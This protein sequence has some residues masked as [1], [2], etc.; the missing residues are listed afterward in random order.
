MT[1]GATR[2]TTLIVAIFLGAVASAHSQGFRA[3]HRDAYGERFQA[4]RDAESAPRRHPRASPH[5]ALARLKYWN[6]I[7]LDCNALDHTPVAFQENRLFGEQLGPTRTSRALAIIHV[8]IFDAINAITGEFQTYSG[9]GA[10]PRDAS[11]N[12]AIAQAA[13]D[14]LVALFPS[15]RPALDQLLVDDLKQLPK[16]RS[17]LDGIDVGRRAAAAILALRANDGSEQPEARLAIEFFSSNEPGKW[18]QDPVSQIPIA[19]GVRWGSVRPF[20]IESAQRFRAPP[21]PHLTSAEYAAAFNEVVRFGG[22][23]VV[24]P[25]ERTTEQTLLALYWAYDGTAQLGTPPRLYNQIAVQIATERH[26]HVAELARLLVLINV[27]M[28]DAAIAAWESKYYYQFWR[29]ITAIRE[30][31]AG[32]GPTGLGDGNSA[33]VGNPTFTPLGAPAT[34][35]I[36]PNFTPP[37]PAYVSGHA[38]F[39]GALFQ[40]LRRFFGTDGVTFTFVSDELNGIMR[41]NTGNIRPLRPRSF[42]SLSEAEEENAQS[43]MYLGIHYQFDKTAG[44]AQGRQIADDVF[45]RAFR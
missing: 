41:D 27:A 3:G 5:N 42:Q 15:Q 1:I 38:A 37:F 18:R 35:F 9:V 10:G 32:T 14:T 11:I 20:V 16:G 26:F 12:A 19:L 21:P 13:H 8:A 7:A 17:Q 40:I 22:D 24:T 45:D 34:N 36:G 25:T 44:V 2:F 31:D 39:G 33:T 6:E 28:A 43:R 4:Q 23:G 29:P 30:S